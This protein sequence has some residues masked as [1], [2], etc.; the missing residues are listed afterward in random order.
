L[1]QSFRSIESIIIGAHCSLRKIFTL[2][3]PPPDSSDDVSNL[4]GY[5]PPFGSNHSNNSSS[6]SS[7]AGGSFS[8]MMMPVDAVPKS[9]DFPPGV[10]QITQIYNMDKVLC[11]AQ[12][13]QTQAT[14]MMEQQR[15]QLAQQQQLQSQLNQLPSLAFQVR[16]KNAGVSA[17]SSSSSSS[18]SSA[19]HHSQSHEEVDESVLDGEQSSSFFI[20]SHSRASSAVPSSSSSASSSSSSFQTPQRL[21]SSSSAT[22]RAQSALHHQTPRGHAF[23]NSSASSSTQGLTLNVSSEPLSPSSSSSSSLQMDMLSPAAVSTP[24]ASHHQQHHLHQHRGSTQMHQNNYAQPYEELYDNNSHRNNLPNTNDFDGED[25]VSMIALNTPSHGNNSNNNSTIHGRRPISGFS[26]ASSS[27]SSP[28]YPHPHP[29]S[30]PHPHP[31]L[32]QHQSSFG[33]I[34]L[35][36][37]A[38]DEDDEEVG[39]V[40]WADQVY[41]MCLCLPSHLL[42]T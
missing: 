3:S 31:H 41:F 8:A 37:E 11:H 30:H 36:E 16:G 24:Y 6:S 10:H 42:S 9:L 1:Y 38:D 14:M 18:S 7:A 23:S 29:Q 19:H 5:S 35:I 21:Q 28:Q 15:Q 34:G 2:R 13:A 4:P 33:L 12:L 25:S 27:S 32:L 40:S 22:K 26:P 20:P 39:S 17:S